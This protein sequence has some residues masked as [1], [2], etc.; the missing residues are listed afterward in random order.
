MYFDEF[1]ISP[2]PLYLYAKLLLKT[3]IHRYE[4]T[5]Q[6]RLVEKNCQQQKIVYLGEIFYLNLL[7]VYFQPFQSNRETFQLV[8]LVNLQS[9]NFP[10]QNF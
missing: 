4:A 7:C 6:N 2:T 1:V 10:N 9:N 8:I 5:L 3:V